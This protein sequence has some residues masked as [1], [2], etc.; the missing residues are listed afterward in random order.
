[1]ENV[2]ALSCLLLTFITFAM[3]VSATIQPLSTGIWT[4]P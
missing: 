2:F 3:V 1:M 4:K